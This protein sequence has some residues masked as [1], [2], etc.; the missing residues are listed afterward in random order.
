MPFLRRRGNMAS[1]TDIRRHTVLEPDDAPQLPPL[2]RHFP[3]RLQQKS[4]SVSLP[5]QP[6]QQPPSSSP[7]KQQKQEKEEDTPPHPTPATS[8]VGGFSPPS[9]LVPTQTDSVLDLPDRPNPA[10]LA[11]RPET[12]PVQEETFKH[13]RF[14]ILRFRNASDSQLSLRVKQQ[15]ET[16]P[17]VPRRMTPSNTTLKTCDLSRPNL[18]L[19]TVL[20][21]P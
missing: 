20:I 7:K 17:P 12:P 14:S 18:I 4:Q 9:V 11:D 8:L 2:P 1:E 3:P 6:P 16:P 10:E 19:L 21:S 5:T 13:R 15:A